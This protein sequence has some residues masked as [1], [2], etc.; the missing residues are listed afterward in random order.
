MQV[1]IDCTDAGDTLLFDVDDTIQPSKR[2][3]IPWNLTMSSA[4]KDS[5]RVGNVYPRATKKASFRC[6]GSTGLFL[7]RSAFFCLRCVLSIPFIARSGNVLFANLQFEGC[8]F[9]GS[10]EKATAIVEVEKCSASSPGRSLIQFHHVRFQKNVLVGGTGLRVR[11]PSCSSLELIDFEL[12]ENVCS[13]QCGVILSD[14]NRLEDVR[15]RRTAPSDSM[16]SRTAVFDAPPGSQTSVDGM[17]AVKNA[18]PVLHVRSASLNMFSATFLQNFVKKNEEHD[19]TSSI[20]L[21]NATVFV[22]KCVFRKN[23]AEIGGAFAAT[24]T[25][26]TVIDSV[27]E[28][29]T[30]QQ[31]GAIHL[32][33]SSLAVQSCNFSFNVALGSGG[34]VL[35]VESH[36]VIRNTSFDDNS[37]S[38]RGGSFSLNKSTS[39]DLSDSTLYENSASQGGVAFFGEQSTGTAIDSNFGFNKARNRGGSYFVQDSALFVQRCGFFDGTGKFGGG[40][41]AL[42]SEIRLERVNASF[43]QAHHSGGFIDAMSSTVLL[44][45]SYLS[46]NNAEHAGGGVAAWDACHVEVSNSRFSNHEA[47]LGG[48]LFLDEE[49][50]GNLTQNEF[51]DSR[52]IHHGGVVYINASTFK[53]DDCRFFSGRANLDGGLLFAWKSRVDIFNSDFVQGSADRDGGCLRLTSQCEA[54]LQNVQFISCDSRKGGAAHLSSRSSGLF[55]NATFD[56]NLA[57]H[58]GGSVCVE[59]ANVSMTQCRFTQRRRNLYVEDAEAEDADGREDERFEGE[60]GYYFDAFYSD[61][62]YAEL[63]KIDGPLPQPLSG[64]F[65][66]SCCNAHIALEDAV[67]EDGSVTGDAGCLYAT[68]STL[69]IRNVTMHNCTARNNGGA[70]YLQN[71]VSADIRNIDVRWSKASYGGGIRALDED[72]VGHGWTMMHNVAYQDGG[73]LS[74]IRSD[75]ILHGAL[76]KNNYAEK[77]GGAVYL[78]ESSAVFNRST[79]LRSRAQH[80]GL[81]AAGKNDTVDI[82]H[83]VLGHSIARRGACVYCD[84]G[85]ISMQN[86]TMHRCQAAIAGGAL[87][88]HLSN[89][90]R[91]KNSRF[92]ENHAQHGG[93]LDVTESTFDGDGLVFESNTADSKGGALFANVSGSVKIVGSQ[94]RNNSAWNGGAVYQNANTFGLFLNTTFTDN[95]AT[96]EGGAAYTTES[97]IRFKRCLFRDSHA[98]RGGV[99]YSWKDSLVFVKNSEL[100]RGTAHSG[101][102]FYVGKGN[103]TVQKTDIHNCSASQDGGAFYLWEDAVA[104]I[105]ESN[106]VANRAENDGGG[107]Y[108]RRSTVSA[109]EVLTRGNTAGDSGGGMLLTESSSLTLKDFHFTE[110]SARSGGALVVRKKTTGTLIGVQTSENSAVVRGGDCLME[111]ATNLTV[112]SSRFRGSTA[113]DGGSFFVLHSYLNITESAFH[114]GNASRQGGFICSTENSGL[115][116]ER[117]SMNDSRSDRGGAIALLGTDLRSRNVEISHGK[118]DGDGGAIMLTNASRLLCEDCHL[119]DNIARRG[120]AVFLEYRDA[121]SHSMQ[122]EESTLQNNSAA[123]GGIACQNAQGIV[124]I[125]SFLPFV[126]G[127]IHA[128]GERDSMFQNCFTGEDGCGVL[129][130]ANTLFLENKAEVAGGAIFTDRTAVIRMHCSVRS[131]TQRGFEFY[132]EK[133]WQSMQAIDSLEDICPT[134][135]NNTAGKYGP[136]VATYTCDIEKKIL[137]K[138]AKDVITVNREGYT[139][140]GHRSGKPI[141]A[142]VLTPIDELGQH[143]A[144]G[145]DDM[146]T[147]AVISSPDGFFAGSMSVPLDT[148]A[149]STSPSGFVQPGNYTVSIRFEGG[150]V[151]G[152]NITVEVKGCSMGE[153][154]S[155]NGTFCEPCTSSTYSFHPDEDVHCHPCPENAKCETAVILPNSGYWHKTPCSQRIQRCLTPDACE[156]DLRDQA[157]K[158]MTTDVEHCDFEE[159]FIQNYTDVECREVGYLHSSI[160]LGQTSTVVVCLAGTRGAP[161]WSVRGILRKDALVS[162]REVPAAV[163]QRHAGHSVFLGLDVPVCYHHQEQSHLRCLVGTDDNRSSIIDSLCE[164][165]IR[166]CQR[167]DGGDD[168][169]GTGSSGDVGP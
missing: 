89:L 26:L 31:G 120:G 51:T 23:E 95:W 5:R 148:A 86:V 109:N 88:L 43:N 142:I 160:I 22:D 72:I 135:H 98:G 76:L 3:T 97:T 2:V 78:S 24:G 165:S 96:G 161:L 92:T 129:T 70:I 128:V 154:P 37:A 140:R 126:L 156:S 157:L 63:G 146:E 83:S 93:A 20:R 166:R 107:V 8:S 18:C 152:F 87:S 103:V 163:K 75:I 28:E 4:T 49:S 82:V 30:A 40:I 50:W 91:I 121:R 151:E 57:L 122:L 68:S 45:R 34:V 6:P 145:A 21:T 144:V 158:E 74:F 164:H 61:T 153:V 39:L 58:V 25:N 19:V 10:A 85:K 155:G 139:I 48:V 125:P 11:S 14:R 65:I 100:V 66:H 117:C 73:A 64:G 101:G 133:Q 47:K 94:F 55:I 60:K 136:D 38:V 102:C 9:D 168:D 46:G 114:S 69:A 127:G 81:V 123:F 33:A 159:A 99:L 79:F 105:K 13:G 15:V 77:I 141:P 104:E 111:E 1:I 118:A 149:V 59:E 44:Q 169:H 84:G 12:D 132:S 113:R 124:S 56:G 29:N 16:D 137:D 54:R 167:T 35:A 110:N 150:N 131:T 67:M 17:D 130:V 42:F 116:V 27:F 62:Y 106:I 90:V 162:V 36:L 143:P 41:Y 115:I 138:R 112:T 52:A 119:T 32:E 80:G 108:S 147:V 134:W 71:S 7:V 53:S